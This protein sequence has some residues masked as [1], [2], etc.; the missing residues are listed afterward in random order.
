M[1]TSLLSG[2]IHVKD[3]NLWAH[4]GVLESERI[5]GQSFNLDF[6][7]WLDLE[8]ASKHDD[9]SLSID[10]RLGI[11]SI[12]KLAMELNCL[13]IEFFSDKILDCLESIY[14]PLPIQIILTKCNPPI[15]GFSGEVAV[16]RRRNFY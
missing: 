1:N 16:E 8:E 6:S 7:I 12:Q 5:N 11:N 10:Y 13:T 15:A 4:V 3:I 9:F 2:A 14:G